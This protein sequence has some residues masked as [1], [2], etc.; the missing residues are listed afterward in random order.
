MINISPN[1]ILFQT[2]SLTIHY[3]GVIMVLAILIAI[4]VVNKLAQ[5]K[6]YNLHQ[7][8]D[9]YFYVIILG[10]IGARF[11]EVFFFS[12]SYYQHHLVDIFKIWNGGL[13]IQGTILF[14]ILTVYIFCKRRKLSFWKYT[15][16]LVVGLSLG[17]SIGRW[18]NFFN[19]EL[20]GRITNL[21]WA[22][23]IERTGNFRHPL[24]LYESILDLLLFFLLKHFF[25]KKHFNG[26]IT[27]LYLGAYSLIRFAMEFLR[28]DHCP[29]VLGFRLPQLV[30]IIVLWV[31][32]I[33]SLSVRYLTKK[34]K[35]DNV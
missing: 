19:Q 24:F 35:H 29:V 8:D 25:K 10:I 28:I 14:G 9:L 23:Y 18:G 30:S 27:L 13:A 6:D 4:Y 22:I 2:N 20:Y 31:A 1:P 33:F 3:Y 5:R 11:Y 16:L 34:E 7:L 32:I 17:Q 15:D 26:S 21:P 12:W